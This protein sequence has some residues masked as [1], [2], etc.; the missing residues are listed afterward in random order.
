M[1]SRAP[2]SSW[3]WSRERD[4]LVF[5]GAAALGLSVG[6]G[7]K[8][9]AGGGLPEWAWL[10]FVLG[11]DVAHVW[12]TLFRT[13]LDRDEFMARRALYVGVPVACYLAGVFLH[14]VS[15]V[16]FWRAL[17]YAAVF[18]FVRQQVGWVAIARSR[19]RL[20]AWLDRSLD[21]LVVYLATGVPLLHWHANA[22]RA[23]H[24]LKEGDFM[25]SAATLTVARALLAPLGTVYALALV[26]Y[27][28]RALHHARAGRPLWAKHLVVVSTAVVWWVGIVAVNDDFAFTVTNVALHGVPYFA[29]LWAYSKAR[30][31]ERPKRLVARVVGAGL[32]AFVSFVLACAFL[33]ELAW[34]RLVWH[35]R[36]WLFGVGPS[37]GSEWNVFLI[38]LL[39]LPQATHYALDGVLWRRKD[40]GVSQARALGFA[41][42]P[43]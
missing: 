28:A 14:R 4:L 13:Y 9:I 7:C 31:E 20:T 40:G 15:S 27:A 8:G 25:A 36:E 23:F 1:A 11:L 24:W 5:G 2:A 10:V 37:I 42:G 12:T 16:W 32:L 39:A 21:E 17:A 22:P 26:A 18:H 43:R 35:E 30:A 19:A 29:L 33:E 6:L 38:P 41:A 34:D 3:L